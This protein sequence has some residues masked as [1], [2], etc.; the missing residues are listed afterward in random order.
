MGD[1]SQSAGRPR[2]EWVDAAK[3]VGIL[4]VVVGH[5]WTRGWPHQLI[6]AWHMPLFFLLAGYLAKPQPEAPL[7]E[8]L[9]RQ[10]LVPWLAFVVLLV[11]ADWLIEGIRAVRPVFATAGDA[12]WALIAHHER[13]T[14]PFTI[15]WFAPC[16]FAARL[17]HNALLRRWPDPLD[18][19]WL[20]VVV[21]VMAAGSRV[22]E[23]AALSPLGLI[24]LPAAL[25]LLWAGTLWRH[26]PP[27]RAVLGGLV[28]LAVAALVWWPAVNLKQGDH[29]LPGLSLAGGIAI[30]ALLCLSLQRAPAGVLGWLAI[31]GRHSVAIMYAHVAFIHYLT[32]YMERSLRLAAA[33]AGS[34]LIAWAA[35][36]TRWTRRVLL[37]QV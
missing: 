13:L 37:G 5:V 14:G 16:L 35:T 3:G 24:G 22:A 33:L 6:Y 11:A 36:R 10:L 18:W 9:A 32:P 23:H 29:G 26:Y 19:R 30:A 25:T 1:S 21:L 12:A 31:P 17:I 20:L 7:A 8:R 27:A 4:A 28:I 34:A 2:V 15:L